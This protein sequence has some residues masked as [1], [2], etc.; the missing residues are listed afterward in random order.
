[1]REKLNE[2]QSNIITLS[3]II[4][5]E[6]WFSTKKGKEKRFLE[7]FSQQFSGEQFYK[8]LHKDYEDL[9]SK[10]EKHYLQEFLRLNENLLQE[11][12]GSNMALY[13]E[14]E[15]KFGVKFVQAYQR[16]QG[17]EKAIAN[18]FEVLNKSDMEI[19]QSQ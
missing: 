14:L 9:L 4:N 5:Q 17:Y 15:K 13:I 1:M 2:I 6:K 10:H 11:D 12:N 7:L 16:R 19:F 18:Y 8:L 3:Q